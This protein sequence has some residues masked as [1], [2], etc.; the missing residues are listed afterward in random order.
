MRLVGGDPDARKE[1]L[2]QNK[3][4]P[5]PA[6]GIFSLEPSRNSSVKT[7]NLS[8]GLEQNATS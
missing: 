1:K 2:M 8:T 4:K 7:P 6:R 3:P 5:N